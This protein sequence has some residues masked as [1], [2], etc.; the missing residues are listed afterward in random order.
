M[1]VY[2]HLA[3][4][5]E[6]IE[7]LCAVDVL[8]R[9]GVDVKTVSVMEHRLV[10]GAHGIAVEA[11][12]LF[13]AADYADCGM[14]V[15]P[16]GMPGAK[17]LQNHSGLREKISEFAEKGK[18]LA[19]ICAAPMVFGAMGL[20][21]GRRAVCYPGMESTLSGAVPCDDPVVV[22]GNFITGKGPGLALE[23]ALTLLEVLSG[24]GRASE[25][26]ADMLIAPKKGE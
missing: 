5:F 23:F 8:R 14:I 20:L 12:L 21:A 24:S 16:G 4:G 25:V 18:W 17:N 13:S 6:E 10:K 2:V 22:D 7:A 11:D 1:S 9:G 19:A 26:R 15:L 3:D